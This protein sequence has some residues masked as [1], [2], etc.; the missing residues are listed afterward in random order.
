MGDVAM[1]RAR[2]LLAA[3]AV[4]AASAPAPAAIPDAV[5][6]WSFDEEQGDTAKSVVVEPPKPALPAD[7]VGSW[8]FDEGQGDTAKDASP[9]GNDGKLKGAKWTDGK[10]GK[11]VLF[12]GNAAV[13][14]A[15]PL[16]TWLA[17]S[18][19]LAFWIKSKQ[20]GNDTFWQAPAIAGVEEAGAGDDIFWGWIDGSGKLGF[21]A[22]DTAGPVSSTAVCDGSW[23]YVVLTRD[24]D[25]GE[26]KIYVDGKLEAGGTSD[27]GEK[28]KAF[29]A[30]GRREN[31]GGDP[32]YFQGALDDV[33]VFGRVLTPDEVTVLSGGA[34][35]GP[36]KLD[37]ALKGAK[38]IDGKFG[39]AVELD[40]ASACVEV[41]GGLAAWMG[42]T[43]SLSCWIRTKQA[44]ND[45]LAKAPALAG[46]NEI[47]WGCLTGGGKLAMKAGDGETAV[48]TTSV[49]DGAWHHVVLTRK[50]TS[51]KVEI[52]VDGKQEVWVSSEAQEKPAPFSVL[53][54]REGGGAPFQGALDEVRLYK[55]ILTADEVASLFKNEDK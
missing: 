46:S 16:N 20:Q 41:P 25:S 50:H 33:K 15:K 18:A 22:G 12:E 19:S 48:G 5:A 30:L 9:S 49:N 36:P 43:A 45:D 3:A 38:R 4:L 13:E 39:K 52:Y 21:Q 10:A 11:A 8:A 28:T 6:Y 14:F 51:G 17:K 23:H 55:R 1:K 29:G 26:A 53:G 2:V 44:G 34:V 37:A 42:K 7:C 40:G 27:G 35:A 54:R 31:T 32:A 47:L 24:M